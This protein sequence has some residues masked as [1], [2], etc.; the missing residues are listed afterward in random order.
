MKLILFFNG[1]GMDEKA[2]SH[3]EIPHGFE[4]KVLNYPYTAQGIEFSRYEKLYLVAWSFGV[5]YASKFVEDNP[6]IEFKKKIAING[7]PE[8]IGNY[9]IPEKIFRN[10]LDHLTPESLKE[11]YSNMGVSEIPSSKEF[12]EI[13]EELQYFWDNYIPQ[14]DIY[15][16][17]IV[18]DEDIII[19]SLR[20]KKQHK[21]NLVQI[22]EIS[23]PHYPFKVFKSWIE[24]ID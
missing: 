22:R 19:P 2:I 14:K 11:F 16:L 21:K 3:L 9:G 24:M 12:E 1:W 10:T 15:D 4:V 17:A 23:A 6:N 20:Q 13:R 18:G 7:V 5:Y 8:T